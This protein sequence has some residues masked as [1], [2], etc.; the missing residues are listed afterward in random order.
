M[1]NWFEQVLGVCP[2]VTQNLRTTLATVAVLWILHR[3]TLKNFNERISDAGVRYQWQKVSGY[4][5][6][7][8]VLVIGRTWDEGVQTVATFLGLLSAGLVIALK[9]PI[10]NLFAW[11]FILWRQLFEVG[12]RIEMDGFAAN[13]DIDLA[14]PTQRFYLGDT[15]KRVY[16]SP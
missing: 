11:A 14:Y 7:L 13:A 12:D 9:D 10:A 5:F 6:L 8:G 1:L 3:I 16:N 15:A 2:Q 4:V